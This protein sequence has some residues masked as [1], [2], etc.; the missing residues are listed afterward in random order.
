MEFAVDIHRLDLFG[1]PDGNA[2]GDVARVR[3]MLAR[4]VEA[5]SLSLAELQ[6][7]RDIAKI[8]GGVCAEAYVFLAAMF[9]SQRG[10]NTFLRPEKGAALLESA[11]YLETPDGG[12]YSN[13]AFCADVREVWPAA[14]R[15]AESLPPG[16]IVLDRPDACGPR[17]FFQRNAAAVDAVSAALSARAGDSACSPGLQP[18]ELEAAT[19]FDGFSLN[20][21]QIDAVKT[22]TSRMFTVVTGGPG[23][24]KTTIVF[25]ILRAL[26]K[27]GL[28]PEDVALVAPTA[29][30]ARRMVETLG[31]QI[32]KAKGLDDAGRAQIEA[33]NGSTIHS[34]LGGFPPRWKYN[35]GNRLPLKLVVADESS[36]VDIHLMQALVEALPSN[37][38]LVLMGDKNQLPSVDA[39]AVLGDIVGGKGLSCVARLGKSN[40]F[41]GALAECAAVV[42]NGDAAGFAA[43]SQEVRPGDASWVDAFDSPETENNCYRFMLDGKDRRAVCHAALVRWAEHF[44]LL[45]GGLLVRLASDPSLKD[46]PALTDGVNSPKARAIFAAL[47]CSRI[48]TVVRGGPFGVQGVNDLLAMKRFGGRMPSN[49]LEAAGVPVVVTRNT[50]SRDLWNGDVGVTVEGRRGM[51]VLFPRGGKVVCCPVSLLPDHELAYAMTVHKSQGSEFGNVMMVLP[52]DPGHPLLDRQ[53]LYTGITRARKRAVVLGT[54]PALDAAL[55]KKLERDTGI[56]V[57]P[58]DGNPS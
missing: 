56:A 45:P 55:E 36:M 33:L 57:C 16:G 37:C 12:V 43:L 39:G 22:A 21:E 41:T 14:V 27:R 30:A 5:E 51:T 26:F 35:A 23:T 3:K 15:A 8:S 28:A 13:D 24:G 44:G 49:P 4:L 38:R 58:A 52:G 2:P 20:S 40:R 31:R 48:L 53:I 10:G 29:R 54:Q 7:A 17:W 42:N 50:P 1:I 9:V 25:A 46:D 11:G 32:L 6:T 19:A 18:G 47:D 34:L